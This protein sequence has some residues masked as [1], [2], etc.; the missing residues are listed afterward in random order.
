MTDVN[1]TQATI[2][3]DPA[4]YP[5]DSQA[6]GE[7]T[8]SAADPSEQS[9]ANATD[10]SVQPAEAF[11][12][13]ED[14]EKLVPVTEAIRYRKRAQQAEQQLGD[15]QQQMQTLQGKLDEAEQ[16]IQHLE[17]RQ[18]IDALLA[19]SEPIDTE[20]VRLLTEQAIQQMEEP[21]VQ[22]AVAELRQSRPYLFQP[23]SGDG[24]S[25][26]MAARFEQPAARDSEQAAEHAAMSGDRR[27]LLRYLRL[28]RGK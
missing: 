1:E 2:Q 24:G 6:N 20:A 18:K 11:S 14:T 19:E 3:P 23:H 16:T 27:D 8:T 9:S 5:S 15:M 12:T 10:T 26:A 13:D 28:R 25:S 21:D 17:R 7:A 22:A 4:A